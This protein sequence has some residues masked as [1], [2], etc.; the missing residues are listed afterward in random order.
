MK[1]QD[2]IPVDKCFRIKGNDFSLFKKG[3]QNQLRVY[4][5]VENMWVALPRSG[6]QNRAWKD[7]EKKGIEY[8]DEPP[9]FRTQFGKKVLAKLLP[10]QTD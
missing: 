3:E 9:K 4:L 7:I 2:T 1:I 10:Q 8:V 6:D 5:R